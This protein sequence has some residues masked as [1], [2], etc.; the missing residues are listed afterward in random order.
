[1]RGLGCLLIVSAFVVFGANIHYKVVGLDKAL[2]AYFVLAVLGALFYFGGRGGP[3][4][5]TCNSCGWK[6]SYSRY[7]NNGGCPRCGSDYFSE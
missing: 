4:I 6:G 1:M 3:R 5:V 7:Q 2:I